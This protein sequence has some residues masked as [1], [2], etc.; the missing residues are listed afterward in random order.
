MRFAIV[1]FITVCAAMPLFAQPVEIGSLPRRLV[2]IAGHKRHLYC[3][4]RG[5][6]TVVLEGGASAFVIDWAPAQTE[7][8][9]RHVVIRPQAAGN[10]TQLFWP[11]IH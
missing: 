1:L 11:A 6:P 8:A 4:G 3:S 7:I 2:D 5:S 9:R 10:F